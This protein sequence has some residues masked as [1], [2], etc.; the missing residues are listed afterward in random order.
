MKL[1]RLRV[2]DN[3]TLGKQAMLDGKPPRCIQV[4]SKTGVGTIGD[5]VLVAIKGVKKKAVIV[6]VKGKK[7]TPMVPRFDSNNIVLIDDNGNP[8][9]SRVLVPIPSVLRGRGEYNKLMSLC[10]RFV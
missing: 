4:Y 6:G 5:K 2:V 9:G 3:S 10:S 8:L 1:T 7:P